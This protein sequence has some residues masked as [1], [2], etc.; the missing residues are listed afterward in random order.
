MFGA[1]NVFVAALAFI[2]FL[3]ALHS[4]R[5]DLRQQRKDLLLQRKELHLITNEY[6]YMKI[7]EMIKEA[8][9][10]IHIQDHDRKLCPR[11]TAEHFLSKLS[12]VARAYKA[13][14]DNKNQAT[15]DAAINSFNDFY[16]GLKHFKKLY[17]LV[18]YYLVKVAQDNTLDDEQIVYKY[19]LMAF[20]LDDKIKELLNI[21]L[22]QQKVLKATKKLHKHINQAAV[23]R[24]LIRNYQLDGRTLNAM[25]ASFI[26]SEAVTGFKKTKNDEN[27]FTFFRHS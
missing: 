5:V 18:C 3:Y 22:L 7:I 13:Y 27:I 26:A 24:W 9:A 19:Y 25:I 21:F 11:K 10:N 16:S 8:A 1:L 17:E 2:G 20:N 23:R 14:F 12:D 6:V 4:Q 15:G